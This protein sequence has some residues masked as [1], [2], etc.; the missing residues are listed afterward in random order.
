[1]KFL[2]IVLVFFNRFDARGK[3]QLTLAER[4][5]DD[6]GFGPRAR[7]VVPPG[8]GVTGHASSS[9]STAADVGGRA[10]LVVETVLA[11]DGGTYKCRTDFRRS[12]TRNQRVVLA[13]LSE[14]KRKQRQER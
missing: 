12:P 13:V 7:M 10:R 11:S 5:S 8:A 2:N 4:Y 3:S 14:W 6:A 9:L 1:L